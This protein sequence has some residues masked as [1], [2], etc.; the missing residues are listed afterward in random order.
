MVIPERRKNR[1]KKSPR[2][3]LEASIA[4]VLG[5]VPPPSLAAASNDAAASELTGNAAATKAPPT[6]HVEEQV[7]L[8][9]PALIVDLIEFG[10]EAC[11][12]NENFCGT[13]AITWSNYCLTAAAFRRYRDV[14]MSSG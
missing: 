9:T 2:A 1:N 6:G 12:C 14:S 11:F 5:A 13:A 10:T 3:Q 4:K 7:V 8:K